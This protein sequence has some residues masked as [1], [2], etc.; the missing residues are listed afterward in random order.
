MPILL[1]LIWLSSAIALWICA[2]IGYRRTT[3][4]DHETLADKQFTIL[5]ASIPPT[6]ILL[7]TAYVL[8]Q[9]APTVQFNAGSSRAMDSWS[10]WVQ[11][12]SI[13]FGSSGV[14]TIG[15]LCWYVG[16][17]LFQSWNSDRP[18][19]GLALS[20][21]LRGSLLLSMAFPTA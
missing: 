7:V 6:L 13:I 16:S 8:L 11:W 20:T 17:F 19:Q 2:V 3:T 21:S 14:M 15:Y 9:A 4:T 5:F 18:I 12:Y 10:F 1:L